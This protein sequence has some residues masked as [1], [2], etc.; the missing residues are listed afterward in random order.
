LRVDHAYFVV[1]GLVLDGQYGAADAVDVNDGANFLTLRNVEV[2]RS[3]K[4]LIDIGRP[5]GVLI[6]GSLVHHALNATGGRT[7][8]H[9][10]VAGAVRDLT[11]RDTEIH[12][13]SGDGIQVDPGRAAPG[14]D[15]VTVE[16]CRIWLAPLPAAANGFAA[17]VVAGENA[18][19]TKANASLSRATLVIRDTVASGYRGGLISNMAAFNLKENVDVTVDGVTVYDS[20]IAFR[21]RGPGSTTAGASV[22]VKNAVVYNVTTAF[23]Y[24]DNIQNLRIWNSTVGTGVTRAFQAASSSSAG[25]DVRNLLV[26]GT[27][28]AEAAHVSNLSVGGAAF[29]NAAGHNYELAAGA[30]AIDAGVDL[31][32]VSA[33]RSGTSRPQ[34]SAYDVGAYEWRQ[35]GSAGTPPRPPQNVRIVSQ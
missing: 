1:E 14:W 5:Q 20:E 9:G 3:S 15:R 28:P 2:R 32:A 6:E 34:G 10:I 11:I 23:R 33:D 12:T 7:D 30:A 26:L 29:V 18:I 13:F 8:A 22:A 35:P 27:R 21:L 25:L 24:E 31:A 16:R 17:G 19:D 4:D